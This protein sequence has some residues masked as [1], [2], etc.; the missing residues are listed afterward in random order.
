MKN[1]FLGD[2]KFEIEKGFSK[3]KFFIWGGGD[4]SSIE[5]FNRG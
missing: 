1:S 5:N 2:K 4:S 3:L